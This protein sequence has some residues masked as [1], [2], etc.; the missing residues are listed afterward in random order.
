[1]PKI[2]VIINAGSGTES[3]NDALIKTLRDE[4]AA[5]DIE[6]DI[7]LA[8]SG[9]QLVAFAV[10][11]AA[12]EC[13]II[14]AGGGDGTI[15]AVAEEV[16]KTGK[17]LGVLPLGTLN[18][19]SR[20]LKIPPVPAEAINVIANGR[21]VE[22]DVGEVNGRIFL[23]NSSIGLYP[24]IV[25]K[26]EQQQHRLRRGKWPAAFWAAVAVLRRYPFLHIKIDIGG[27]ALE[28]KTPF[29]FVGNNRYEMEGFRIGARDDL[30][31]GKLSLYVVQR[32]GRLGLVILALRSLFKMLKQAKDFEEYLVEEIEI[33]TKRRKHLL[34]ALDGEV[35]AMSA[36][37]RYK[38]RPKALKVMVS[39]E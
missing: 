26:R 15:S 14:V 12:S 33:K 9:E 17:I 19:F 20:D 29:V 35:S 24:H 4:F 37:L 30:D 16:I 38:I 7:K 18:H 31:K 1:M 32:T 28:R 8:E 39:N 21:G 25:R 11:A 34:V 10:E 23:N 2:A 13:E 36:P 27:K 5:H 6:A 3:D 22:I